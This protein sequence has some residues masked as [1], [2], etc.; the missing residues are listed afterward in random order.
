MASRLRMNSS[1]PLACH[2]VGQTMPVCSHLNSG[3]EQEGADSSLH[4]PRADFMSLR[5]STV[6]HHLRTAA[7]SGPR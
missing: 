7:E 1:G 4:R 5:L 2:D 3:M 6:L